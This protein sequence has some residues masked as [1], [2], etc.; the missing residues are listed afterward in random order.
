MNENSPSVLKNRSFL[1]LWTARIFSTTAFQML[2]VA[3]GWQMY[4]LTHDAFQLGLVGLAQFLPMLLLTLPAGQTA[5]RFDRRTIVYV[6]QLV[7][8]AVVVLLVLGSVQ[9]W[10]GSV[11]I[12][13][14]AAVLGACRT[15]ESPASAA[16]VPD[17][18]EKEQL[19]Q[20]AAW[21]ASAG[22]TAMIVGP[23]LGG[24]LVAFGTSYAYVASLIALVLSVLLIFGVKVIRYVKKPDAVGMNTFLSGLRFVFDRKIILGTIS[25]DLFA[26]LLGGATALLPIFA[27]DILKTG[28]LGLGLL[29]SA[30]AVGALAVSLVLTRVSLENAIGKTLFASLAV[31]ALATILFGVSRSLILSLFALF[32]IGASDVVS[33]VIRSTLVQIN[34]PQDMQ[35]RVNAVNSLFIGTSNQLGEFESGTMAGLV[36]AVPATIIGGLGTLV[37]AVLWMYRLF[38]MLRT[39]KT[40]TVE[41]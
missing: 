35:G 18:V 29:R 33:V 12:L 9:G 26:V 14:A 38:P 34:T 11:H 41:D 8:S 15:F 7:E 5:D 2:S 10:I 22:Q 27:E 39:L 3:I 32:L 28:S 30:P 25:L 21:S 23:S 6:S 20:A 40:Y 4:A 13:V 37:V 24:V 16:L 17:L 19:P 36:G 1:R 31:F